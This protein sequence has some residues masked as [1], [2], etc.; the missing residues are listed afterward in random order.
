MR[1]PRDMPTGKRLADGGTGAAAY[2]DAIATY[3]GLA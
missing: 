1:S 2:A 3:L